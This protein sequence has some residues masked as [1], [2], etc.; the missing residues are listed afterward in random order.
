MQAIDDACDEIFH[1]NSGYANKLCKRVSELVA[2]RKRIKEME[3]ENEPTKERSD[4]EYVIVV[5]DPK[6]TLLPE[7]LEGYVI[8]KLPATYDL[9]DETVHPDDREPQDWPVRELDS[10]LDRWTQEEHIYGRKGKKCF[11]LDHFM[12]SASK[13]S[14]KKWGMQVKQ[15]TPALIMPVQLPLLTS[16]AT[17]L[18]IKGDKLNDDIT[19]IEE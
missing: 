8:Q 4:K 17:T 5:Y 7:T 13:S 14:L 18:V 15:K 19:H 6:G 9:G 3:Q 10:R 2:E 1:E 16:L 11:T 12:Q